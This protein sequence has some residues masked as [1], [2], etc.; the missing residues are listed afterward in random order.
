MQERDVPILLPVTGMEGAECGIC[1]LDY[2]VSREARSLTA[3][4]H[5]MCA[6]CLL[7]LVGKGGAVTCPFCRARSKLPGDKEDGSETSGKG[8]GPGKWLKRLYRKS[9]RS[10][11]VNLAHDDIRDLALMSSYFI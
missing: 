10:S 7:Q 6:S 8:R 4:G 11:Q 1:Y 3:C 9:R 5:V 2:D